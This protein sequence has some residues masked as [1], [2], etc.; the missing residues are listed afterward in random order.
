[1]MIQARRDEKFLGFVAPSVRRGGVL[2]NAWNVRGLLFIC[3]I[4]EEG[5]L[6]GL[7]LFRWDVL[8]SL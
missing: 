3:M 8:I 5:K 4:H 6:T 7:T 1:M 2:C